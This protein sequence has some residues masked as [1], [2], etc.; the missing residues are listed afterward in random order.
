MEILPVY[1]IKEFSAEKNLNSFYSNNL[2]THLKSHQFINHAHKHSTYISILFTAGSGEHQIDFDT[3]TVRKGSVFLLNPGQVHCWK[4]S[5]D[6][7]GYVFFHTKE[8]YDGS[9]TNR[10]LDHFP[11]FYLQQN[12]P[13]IYLKNKDLEKIENLYKE[14]N[15]EF[16]ASHPFRLE[17]LESLVDIVYIELTR[18][19]QSSAETNKDINQKYL[20]VKKLQKLID[21]HF[22]TKKFPAEY[23][24]LL[25]MSTRHLSRI[26]R[27]TLNRSTNDL[28]IDRIIMEAKR[29]LVHHDIN[30][31]QLADKLNYDDIS[32]FTRLFKKKTGMSPKKFQSKMAK[33]EN[34]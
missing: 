4:L 23:A 6:A 5:K 29:M 34:N 26:C 20:K 28:I 19:Y 13:V 3:F 2:T 18:L 24:D 16:T 7:D 12:H 31:S 17:K 14:I 9:Y 21:Q 15:S 22:R 25:N 32:Y 11:F 30:I 27:E 33:P 10:R 8:F 1:G